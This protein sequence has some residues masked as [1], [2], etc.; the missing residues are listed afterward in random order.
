[1]GLELPKKKDSGPG[2]FL[3]W[4]RKTSYI[5]RGKS[6]TCNILGPHGLFASL[7]QTP[8][9]FGTIIHLWV[10]F[11]KKKKKIIS[12]FWVMNKNPFPNINM[13]SVRLE[14]K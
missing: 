1:M 8:S 14:K 9:L 4:E 5:W 13:N 11:L 6:L 10:F 12:L 2:G 3:G 7:K